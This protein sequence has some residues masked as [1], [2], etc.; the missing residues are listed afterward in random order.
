MFEINDCRYPK[1]EDTE[2]LRAA[3]LVATSMPATQEPIVINGA[4]SNTE[5]D[6]TFRLLF[7]GPYQYLDLLSALDGGNSTDTDTSA[8]PFHVGVCVRDRAKLILMQVD[9]ITGADLIRARSASGR[10]N[11][12][13]NIHLGMLPHIL[14]LPHI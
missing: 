2:L 1:L 14:P 4:W 6:A 7:P 9:G 11:V 13:S 8:K 12:L 10:S 5:T 3:G